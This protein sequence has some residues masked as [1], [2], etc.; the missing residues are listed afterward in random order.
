MVDETVGLSILYKAYH[1]ND[2]TIL[3][4]NCRIWALQY[5]ASMIE[6]QVPTDVTTKANKFV[7]CVRFGPLSWW[8]LAYPN[9][10]DD[11]VLHMSMLQSSKK[12]LIEFKNTHGIFPM[13]NM[14]ENLQFRQFKVGDKIDARDQA[15]KWHE[16]EVADVIYES[17]VMSSGG[18]AYKQRHYNSE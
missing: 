1:A 17:V 10:H 16:A 2:N 12:I 6:D 9:E 3:K 4:S 5:D 7:N 11:D 13:N 14:I 15:G 18:V 8:M